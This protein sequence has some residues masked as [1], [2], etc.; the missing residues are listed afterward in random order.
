M[1]R[2]ARS[3][4]STGDRKH[5]TWSSHARPLPR[6]RRTSWPAVATA[7]ALTGLVFLAALSAG[8]ALRHTDS[9]RAVLMDEVALFDPRTDFR[10]A[11]QELLGE[12]GYDL[13]V[14][15]GSDVTVSGLK[16]LPSFDAELVILRTHSAVVEDGRSADEVALFTSETAELYRNEIAG[17]SVTGG[18]RVLQLSGGLPGPS[19]AELSTLISVRRTV[20]AD[21]RPYVGVGPD[22]VQDHF[23][24][25]LRPDAV[26]ILMGCDTL[27]GHALS[28]AFLSRGAHAVIGW[29][30]P[31]SAAHTDSATLSL[32]RHIV[33]GA[34]VPDSVRGAMAE[35]GPDPKSGAVLV[36]DVRT[37]NEPSAVA[38]L[39]PGSNGQAAKVR[40]DTSAPAYQYPR[41]AAP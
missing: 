26:V 27:R 12:R 25:P 1:S 17:A 9:L 37:A 22:F 20:G 10:L 41:S 8:K 34:N 6:A 38:R 36:A 18:R 16:S 19:A 4:R 11:A 33:A 23:S 24:G 31:V 21:T 40:I 3:P 30:D 28:D 5:K 2:L 7:S 39:A 14:I 29:S 13:A 35:V 32:L 15:S